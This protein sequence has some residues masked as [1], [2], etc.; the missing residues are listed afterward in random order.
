[1]TKKVPPIQPAYENARGMLSSPMPMS[2]PML[3]NSVWPFVLSPPC[4]LMLAAMLSTRD[5]LRRSGAPSSTSLG[6]TRLA[7]RLGDD[8]RE[9]V[10]PYDDGPA[11]SRSTSSS[12]MWYSLKPELRARS[13]W[14]L[15][16]IRASAVREKQC[17]R[18]YSA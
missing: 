6:P 13:W 8:C 16:S 5:G 10:A 18:A 3:L 17:G 11:P 14:Y 7:R 2:T 4:T 15:S 12:P 9:D 1:M